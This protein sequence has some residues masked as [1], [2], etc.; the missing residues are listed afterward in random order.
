V[1]PLDVLGPVIPQ[2]ASKAIAAIEA[3]LIT[4]YFS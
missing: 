4:L 2:P 1:T 3:G